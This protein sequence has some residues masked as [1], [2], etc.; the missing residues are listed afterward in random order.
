VQGLLDVCRVEQHTLTSA[1]AFLVFR[2]LSQPL[3][4]SHALTL[5]SVT[6]ATYFLHGNSISCCAKRRKK[7]KKNTSR[8]LNTS[9]PDLTH[10]V[11]GK[12]SCFLFFFTVLLV[13][14]ANW[15]CEGAI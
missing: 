2:G 1:A 10:R 7:E 6:L 5:S 9:K 11:D 3:P 14:A 4:L 12:E 13:L 15:P 8:D